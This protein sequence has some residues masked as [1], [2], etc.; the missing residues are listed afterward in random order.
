MG[1]SGTPDTFHGTLILPPRSSDPSVCPLVS[2]LDEWEKGVSK[3][4]TS[5]RLQELGDR[6][7]EEVK[8]GRGTSPRVNHFWRSLSKNRC[9]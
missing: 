7:R 8:E 3:S 6:G 9:V 2:Y 1:E 5:D 4:G